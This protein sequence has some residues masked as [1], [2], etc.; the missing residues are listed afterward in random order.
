MDF[1]FMKIRRDDD[2]MI[3]MYFYESSEFERK[4]KQEQML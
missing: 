4:L 2:L 3:F 1:F